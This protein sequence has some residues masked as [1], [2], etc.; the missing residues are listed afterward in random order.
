MDLLV[1]EGKPEEAAAELDRLRAQLP[2]D[3]YLR[4]R[5]QIAARW[6]TQGDL[7]AADRLL[8]ADS[9]VEA[10]A[11]RGRFRL[12]AGDLKGASD[13]WRDAGPFAGTREEA[14]ARAGILALLQPIQPDTLTGLGTAFQ[15]LDRG[16]S[17][18]A[19][20]GFVRVGATLPVAGGR[21]EVTLL[22]GRIYAAL[23]RPDEAE[24]TLRAAVVPDAPGTAA[25]A[26][27]EL[28]RFYLGRERR[29]EAVVTLER[30]IL[31][32][33]GSALVPQARRLLD[34]ARNAVPRT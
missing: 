30:M 22:G 6:G 1:K 4:M 9:S 24:R 8:E 2:V 20:E 33:P 12:Y 13:L 29:E 32:Y 27:L 7:A 5:R 26:L 25:A 11:L 14:T 31:D 16:D 17:L 21:P 18:A 15:Q 34:Q 10:L 3:D 28:G 23:G 19:A